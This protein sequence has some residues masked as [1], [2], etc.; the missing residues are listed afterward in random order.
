MSIAKAVSGITVEKPTADKLEQLGVGSWPVWEKEESTFDWHYDSVESC[1]FLK[2]D[3]T[4]KTR[5][6][7]VSFG[8]GDFVTFPKGLDCTWQIKTAVRK[9]YR[10]S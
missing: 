6:G 8:K 5:E 4:V 3:V 2:G 10:F 1:Y 7:E 9:H